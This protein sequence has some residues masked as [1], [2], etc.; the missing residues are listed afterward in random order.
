[1]AAYPHKIFDTRQ[2]IRH[3]PGLSRHPVFQPLRIPTKDLLTISYR[4]LLLSMVNTASLLKIVYRSLLAVTAHCEILDRTVAPYTPPGFPPSSTSSSS[5]TYYPAPASNDSIQLLVITVSG[6]TVTIDFNKNETILALKR[7]IYDKDGTP[8]NAQRLHC[9]GRQLDD[10]RSIHSY[11]LSNLDC[12]HV[13]LRLRGGFLTTADRTKTQSNPSPPRPESQ[14]CAA[15][16]RSKQDMLT[17]IHSTVYEYELG[18]ATIHRQIFPSVAE[19][20]DTAARHLSSKDVKKKGRITDHFSLAPGLAAAR[21]E[22]KHVAEAIEKQIKAGGVGTVPIEKEDNVGCF[23]FKNYNSLAPWG[24]QRKV[25]DLN[26]LLKLYDADCALGVELQVQW[27]L[28]RKEDRDLRL[29]RMLLPG[30]DKRAIT[31]HNVHE[32]FNRS[33]YGGTSIATFDRLSQFVQ[34]SGTDPHVLGR[35][36]WMQVGAGQV[37][38]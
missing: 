38:T 27:D 11:G 14:R 36:S 12:I 22:Q 32:K 31:S 13:C 24:E 26:K 4:A 29:D 6:C 15:K 8:L 16:W 37:S 30:K 2:N 3:S 20:K 35:W 1:M 19:L 25:H 21:L 28:A 23:V 7:L 5:P 34:S 17:P 18:A 10:D 33:Q 9:N